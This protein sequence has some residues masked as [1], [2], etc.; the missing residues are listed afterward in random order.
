MVKIVLKCTALGIFAFLCNNFYCNI[1][2]TSDMYLYSNE[3]IAFVLFIS[4]ILSIKYDI[5]KIIIQVN[6]KIIKGVM[7]LGF[8]VLFFIAINYVYT[9]IPMNYNVHEWWNELSF[10][11]IA[12]LPEIYGHLNIMAIT[13]IDLIISAILIFLEF[14]REEIIRR[15]AQNTIPNRAKKAYI[16][17]KI[18][19]AYFKY[20][21]PLIFIIVV[22]MVPRKYVIPARLADLGTIVLVIS[23]I[24][25]VINI[26]ESL[27]VCS[28]KSKSKYGK[29]RIIIVLTMQNYKLCFYN[30]FRSLLYSISKVRS[31]NIFNDIIVDSKDYTYVNYDAI[32]YNLIDKKEYKNISYEIILKDTFFNAGTFCFRRKE[33]IEKM[34]EIEASGNDFTIYYKLNPL[35]HIKFSKEINDKYK[36]KIKRNVNAEK[37]TKTFEQNEIK[38]RKVIGNST[39]FYLNHRYSENE[40]KNLTEKMR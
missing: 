5:L 6:N 39:V 16:L 11:G 27:Y 14:A 9:I 26:I 35:R 12:F 34:H 10:R 7:A 23:L 20:N 25:F 13:S 22:R 4:I 33:F 1:L 18:I 3:N 36:Y 31:N 8:I 37:S 2:G 21:L 28:E 15:E 24:L 32:R 40:V 30:K 38:K 29:E 17:E 19:R